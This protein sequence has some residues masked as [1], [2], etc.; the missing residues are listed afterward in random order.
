MKYFYVSRIRALLIFS[1]KNVMDLKTRFFF[2]K[3]LR[4]WAPIF[5]SRV[6]DW[7]F[8]IIFFDVHS[9]RLQHN[10]LECMYTQIFSFY[11]LTKQCT[12][13][14]LTTTLYREPK[15]CPFDL[16]PMTRD[17]S[18]RMFSRTTI[19]H[20]RHSSTDLSIYSKKNRREP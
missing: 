20:R 19:P 10:A 3:T 18:F 11:R 5:Y 9:D 7:P 13:L 2:L 14:N 4:A 16:Y 8:D 15:G 12:E 17:S 1:L 6:T